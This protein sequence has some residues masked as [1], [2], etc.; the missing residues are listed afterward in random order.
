MF[1]PY[2]GQYTQVY[3]IY[4]ERDKDILARGIRQKDTR[5]LEKV[6]R[7]ISQTSRCVSWSLSDQVDGLPA[8]LPELWAQTAGWAALIKRGEKYNIVSG[9]CAAFNG[10]YDKFFFPTGLIVANPY[11]TSM[12]GQYIFGKNAVLLRN[13]TTLQGLLPII[14]PKCEILT[15]AA[16]TMVNG[17]QNL[18]L[19]N[20]IRTYNDKVAAAAELM[21]KKIRWGRP[22]IVNAE[23]AK[24]W[25]GSSE[26]PSIE[27]LPINGVPPNYITQIVE[28]IQYARATMY[29]DLGIQATYNM[30]RESLNGAEVAADVAT[31][32]PL[33]DDMRAC[34]EEFCSECEKVFGIQVSFEMV[35]S[36]AEEQYEE[37]AAAADPEAEQQADQWEEV[38]EDAGTDDTE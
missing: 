21:L 5:F 7:M 33:I 9:I 4:Y 1:K 37:A 10:Q 29:N 32:R 3:P 17:L 2:I 12:D 23:N 14:C 15:E 28:A 36:W 6:N 26:Q 30:K 25:S 24:T 19:I 11:D 20:L 38:S 18:R 31:L 34:R 27:P 16:V 22:G 8:Y 35:G 13:D